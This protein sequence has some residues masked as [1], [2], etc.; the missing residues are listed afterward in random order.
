[1]PSVECS[2]LKNANFKE[3]IETTKIGEGSKYKTHYRNPKNLLLNNLRKETECEGDY[4][5][6][7]LNRLK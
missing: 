5:K 4:D 1:M 6:T 3:E 7:Y 2:I